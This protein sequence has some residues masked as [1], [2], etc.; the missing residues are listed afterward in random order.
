[1]N[2][3][4]LIR[5]V[6]LSDFCVCHESF[7]VEQLD[8][9]EE[10]LSETLQYQERLLKKNLGGKSW[11]DVFDVPMHSLLHIINYQ[12]CRSSKNMLGLSCRTAM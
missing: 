5:W 3:P 12:A 10:E 2:T 6:I 4:P 8:V 7:T 11:E 1:M 9:L